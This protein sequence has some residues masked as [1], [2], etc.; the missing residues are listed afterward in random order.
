MSYLI[1]KATGV[2]ALDADFDNGSQWEKAEVIHISNRMYRTY[3][4][5]QSL[6]RK[7]TGK[8]K[9]E[10][11]DPY[12]PV[13]DLKLLHDDQFIYGLFRVKDQYVRATSSKFGEQACIDSCVEF[14]IHPSGTERYLNFEFTA[15]G[16]LLV[17]DV[18]DLRNGDFKKVSEED[19]KKVRIFHSLP[20]I[21][22]PEIAEP[23]EWFLGFAVPVKMFGQLGS[24]VNTAVLSGQTWTANA[25]KC[26]ELTSHPHWFT[27][28][29]IPQLDFHLPEYFGEVTF[30]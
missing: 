19:W 23:T 3:G 10:A 17:Y 6:W 14:F 27:W 12:C 25:Y 30:E 1:K 18:K 28:H 5:F 21:I 16:F 22:D 9:A 15:G 4:F 7:I 2:V 20:S 8:E 24:G 11:N 26:A 29:A 13:T